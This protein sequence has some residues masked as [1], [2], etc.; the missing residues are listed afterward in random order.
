MAESYVYVIFWICISCTMI[1]FN[2]AVM[3]SLDFPF[4]MFLTTYHM[5]LST[6]MTQILAST[7][8]WLPG[9]AENKVNVQ[10]M[11]KQIL[12][13]SLFFAISLV[14]SNKAYIYLSVSYIQMLKAFTP[15]AVLIFSSLLGLEKPTFAE[16]AIVVVICVGVALTSAGEAA[17]SMIGF[18][19]QSLAILFESSRLVLTNILLK[20][21]KLD[22][23]SSL[24]YIAPMCSF[25]I[26]I[27]FFVFEYDHLPWERL[28]EPSFLVMLAANGCVAFTLNV[29]VVMLISHTSALTLT[30]AGIFKDILLVVLSVLVFGSPVTPLQVLGYAVALAGLNLHKEYKKSP[31]KVMGWLKMGE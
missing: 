11:Q 28:S 12:P 13:V 15:V 29:A 18:T 6:V 31:A 14:L 1:M 8:T 26:G 30:L 20:S 17:F 10:V 24:Y 19:F 25:F 2:K 7:S 3:S 27:S 23:L 16:L 22:P 9:V 21:L 5:A 4:P